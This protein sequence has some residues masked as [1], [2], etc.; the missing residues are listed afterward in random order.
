MS[1]FA[2]DIVVSL[3]S[4][5]VTVVGS[6]ITGFAVAFITIRAQRK[7]LK[8]AYDV[9][10]TTLVEPGGLRGTPLVASVDPNRATG[11]P[12]VVSASDAV[13]SAYDFRVRVRN[14][15]N[16]TVGGGGVPVVI[17]TSLD[18]EATII[19]V[20]TAPPSQPDYEVRCSPGQQP[21]VA[22]VSFP[23]I[24]KY[25][26]VTVRLVSVQNA[27]KRC[28]VEILGPGVEAEESSIMAWRRFREAMKPLLRRLAENFESQRVGYKPPPKF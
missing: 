12:T 5:L 6:A 22:S 10:C 25:D 16:D 21:N 7:R 15:G 28:S 3:G 13:G 11:C 20:Q 14:V 19:Q 9:T 18:T 23:Y 4:A 8:V 26:T 27:G 24:N 1:P 17:T 2:Q